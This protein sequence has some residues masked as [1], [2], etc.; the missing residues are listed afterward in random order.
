MEKN[1]FWPPYIAGVGLGITLLATFYVV[2]WGLAASSAF[3]L[4]AGVGTREVN[5]EYAN[6]LKYFARYLDVKAPLLNWVL[7][8]IGGL[9]LGALAGSLLSGNFRPKFDKAAQMKNVT[10]LLT[11]F[12]G[13]VLIGFASRLA[14]GCT[15]GVALSGGAELALSGWIFVIAMFMSGFIV[16]AFFRRLW[17]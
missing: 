5:P 13:G 7:F 14:R 17:S 12:T 11:A 15:S 3:S 2:G 1:N 8:E 10:R 6:S 4:L 9:F 16:A